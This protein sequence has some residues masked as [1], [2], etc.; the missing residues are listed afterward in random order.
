MPF[1]PPR[2]KMTDGSDPLPN[3]STA[4]TA[5]PPR[6][7]AS[8][9]ASASAER[10]QRIRVK[11]RR[12]RYLDLHPEYFGPSLELADPMLYDRLV[13]RFQSAAERRA[14]GLARGY[15][16]RLEADLLRSE[17]KLDAL[18]HPDPSAHLTYRR[19]ATGEIVSEEGDDAPRSKEEGLARWREVMETRFLNG[20]DA[21]FEYADVDASEKYDDWAEEEREREE[22]YFGGEEP[23][24]VL[25]EIGE[26]GGGGGEGGGRVVVGE[27]GVQDY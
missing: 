18:A 5:Q 24:W 11:N 19:R 22:A 10:L 2:P 26:E 6:T 21:E 15:S 16:G 14:E 4:Q 27:T 8:A 12:K 9:S 1:F 7:S 25:D 20:G 3:P 17:A 23:A 13:R